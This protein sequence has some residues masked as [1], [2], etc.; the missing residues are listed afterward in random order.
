[1]DNWSNRLWSSL[2]KKCPALDQFT[3]PKGDKRGTHK[4]F[5]N[6]DGNK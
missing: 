2:Q 6:L 5:K 3:G 4:R 1:M